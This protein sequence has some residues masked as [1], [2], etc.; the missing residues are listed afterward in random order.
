MQKYHKTPKGFLC[1]T[2]QNMRHRVIKSGLIYYQDKELL[3]RNKF[4]AWALNNTEF[5]RL[6]AA[7]EVSN[8]ERNITPSINRKNNKLGYT[9]NNIEWIEL[10]E[11]CTKGGLTPKSR[12]SDAIGELHGMAKLTQLDVNNLRILHKIGLTYKVLSETY[13]VSPHHVGKIIRN[14]NW[15]EAK[16]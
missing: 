10:I 5:I 16:E 13:G 4:Y 14:E 15:K 11:N 7:W 6:F 2:Y 8:Y 12:P 1:S 9:L 3:S